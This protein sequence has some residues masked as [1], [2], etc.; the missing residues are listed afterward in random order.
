M[1]LIGAALISLA[2]VS[3]EKTDTPTEDEGEKLPVTIDIAVQ[4][5]SD[6]VALAQEGITVALA[7]QSGAASFEEKTDST[8]AAHYTVVVG[9]YTASATFTTAADG[10]KLVYSGSNSA[11]EVVEQGDTTFTIALNKVV[12]QQILIKELYNG[13][14]LKEDG[15]TAYSNDAYV[16]LYNNTDVE[17]DAS[18]IV[19]T[20]AGPYNGNGTNKY[21]TEAGVLAYE[22]E[23]WIPAYGAIWW[24]TSPVKIAPYSSLVVACFG[25]IDHTS[26]VP[27]SVNLSNA[28]YYVMSNSDVA[29]YTNAKYA[30]SEAI[31]TTHYLTTVPISPGNAWALS[32]S[33]PAFYIGRMPAADAKALSEDKESFDKGLGTTAALMTAKFP[34]ANVIDAVE[35]WATAQ[36][37]ASKVRFSADVN[38]GSV[39][40]TNKM[41]YSVY[42]NVDKAATEALPENAG[43]LVYDY[44]GTSDVEGTTDPSAIDAE[45]SIAAGAHIIYVNTNNSTND[46]HQRKTASLKK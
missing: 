4:L 9:T 32:N 33:A 40:L 8:G 39:L 21:Y 5:T 28:D 17:A 27:N 2:A 1:Y 42:R 37:D 31:P 44:V 7:D 26:T 30:V 25:A 24:F 46:F 14:C 10:N 38:S 41:G 36:K 16:V 11:I 29:A 23:D 34:K 6:G 18:D 20:F 45:A 3:C 22:S 15:K 13:G 35:V 12:S 43:K 19:F